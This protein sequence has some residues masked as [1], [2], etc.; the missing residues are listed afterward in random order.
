MLGI[1]PESSQIEIRNSIK[2]GEKSTSHAGFKN[3][4]GS[5]L[6]KGLND[7]S[8]T[9]PQLLG[10]NILKSIKANNSGDLKKT[11]TPVSKNLLVVN[12]NGIIKF[13]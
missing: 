1:P 6:M 11:G 2:P 7:R 3:P 13:E 5:N 12:K 8:P 4:Y 9:K 10:Q